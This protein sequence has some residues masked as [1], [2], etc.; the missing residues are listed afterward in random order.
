M[1]IGKFEATA[2]YLDKAH[3]LQPINPDVLNN[4][5]DL[6]YRQN[7][8]SRGRRHRKR[9]AKPFHGIA[10]L[11]TDAWLNAHLRLS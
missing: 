4:L 7:H 1:E 8:C 5:G 10:N 6:F 9:T 3:A 2:R 11:L